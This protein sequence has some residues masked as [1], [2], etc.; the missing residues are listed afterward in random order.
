MNDSMS[1]YKPD[2]L[3]AKERMTDWWAGKKIGRVAASVIAP[4]K[5]GGGFAYID[6]SPEK[7][8][9]FDTVSNNLEHRLRGAFWG[10]DAFPHHAVDLNAS[11]IFFGAEPPFV[12][13][14]RRHG[15]YFGNL[16]EVI[17]YKN[18][19]ESEWWSLLVDMYKKTAAKSDGSFVLEAIGVFAIIDVMAGLVGDEKLLYAMVDDPE[20]V[21][22]ARDSMMKWIA[23]T[24]DMFHGIASGC[25]SGGSMSIGVWCP[26]KMRFSQCD[27]SVMISPAMFEKYVFEELKALYDCLDHGIY[28]LDGEEEI[29]HL[30]LILKLDK[31]DMIQWVP[32]TRAGD[33][34]YLDPL[35][36][37]GLIRRIQ[38]AGRK[39]L[40]H[41]TPHDKIKELLNKIDRDL[42]YLDIRCPDEQTANKALIDLEK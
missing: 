26:G 30:D 35:N 3:E 11:M 8:I 25:N 28:H 9:D 29:R 33:P 34:G 37:V 13:N 31:V 20:K 19:G 7:Y 4:A 10:G 6:K 36:W 42:V 23:P 12:S 1:A 18:T 38:D 24:C 32:T 16:D 22:E 27:F 14:A 17:S 41:Y 5:S 40:V 21:M 15:S 2:W 39:V